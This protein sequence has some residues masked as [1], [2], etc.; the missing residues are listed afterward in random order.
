MAL[1]L[2]RCR[3]SMRLSICTRS[4]IPLRARPI[5]PRSFSQSSIAYSKTQPTKDDVLNLWDQCT[6]TSMPAMVGANLRQI[7]MRVYRLHLVPMGNTRG[8]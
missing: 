8:S 5:L 4:L 7:A 2:S 1:P 6:T 3:A